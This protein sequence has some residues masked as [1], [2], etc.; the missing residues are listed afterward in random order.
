MV[1]NGRA[2]VIGDDESA[3]LVKEIT[4][5]GS[6]EYETLRANLVAGHPL[7]EGGDFGGGEGGGPN[8]DFGEPAI[9]IT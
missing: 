3:L 2:V 5:E 7:G 6:V 9:Q 8:A 1:G 4:N